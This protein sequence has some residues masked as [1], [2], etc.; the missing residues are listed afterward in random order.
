MEIWEHKAG[1]SPLR[2]A[3]NRRND[4]HRGYD[5]IEESVTES[6]QVH[7]NPC[8]QDWEEVGGHGLPEVE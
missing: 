2:E 3:L 7:H 6:H 5:R 8:S 4:E 1:R